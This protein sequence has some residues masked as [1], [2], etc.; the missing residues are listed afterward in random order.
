MAD[1]GPPASLILVPHRELAYQYHHWL[2]L[3]CRGDENVKD[4]V[5]L[6]IRG[7]PAHPIPLHLIKNSPAWLIG[8]RQAKPPSV[9]VATPSALLELLRSTPKAPSWDNSRSRRPSSSPLRSKLPVD[10]LAVNLTSV[11]VDEIDSLLDLPLRNAPTHAEEAWLRHVPPVVQI[12]DSIY[13]E[14]TKIRHLDKE[15]AAGNR[16]L[17]QPRPQLVLTSATLGSHVRNHVFSKTKWLRAPADPGKTLKENDVVTWLDFSS[18]AF[19][20]FGHKSSQ[21]SNVDR[22]EEGQEVSPDSDA[23]V[24][25]S[26]VVVA[27]NGASARNIDMTELEKKPYDLIT[28]AEK[29]EV[30]AAKETSSQSSHCPISCCAG[31]DSDIL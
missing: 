14:K 7:D 10:S 29:N 31:A 11:L 9:I 18:S 13:G 6:C 5:Q 21:K 19:S 30:K 22:R 23:V 3:L 24:Q 8:S 25:H 15:S 4:I 16:G 20:P 27:Q 17:I 2:Q 28:K 1:R 12:L 26:C